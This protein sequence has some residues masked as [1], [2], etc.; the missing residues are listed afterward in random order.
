MARRNLETLYRAPYL[1]VTGA[2]A[3]FADPI[4][5]LNLPRVMQQ[6]RAQAVE[7]QLICFNSRS[8]TC[9]VN[10]R[11]CFRELGLRPLAPDRLVFKTTAHTM[12]RPPFSVSAT[13][14]PRQ[15]PQLPSSRMRART[16]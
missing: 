9:E 13:R 7:S 5:C 8:E 3:L 10:L 6:L 15:A 12:P 14:S 1:L 2:L 11:L 16:P 4:R